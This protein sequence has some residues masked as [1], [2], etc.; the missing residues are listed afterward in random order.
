[1]VSL[2][3]VLQLLMIVQ[4]MLAFSENKTVE[5]DAAR[6]KKAL[7][8]FTVVNFPNTACDSSTSGRNGTCYTASECSSKGGSSSGSCASSFGVCCVFEMSCGG[9]SVSENSTYF[10]SSDRTLGAACSLTICKLQS[11]VCQLRLDFESF[12]LNNPVTVTTNS[13]LAAAAAGIFSNLGACAV[14]TFTV[15]SPGGKA[16]PS[17]C[18]TN[19]GEHMYV[20]ASDNCNTLSANIGSA[21]T[22]TTSAFTIKVTQIECSSKTKAPGGCLQYFT[23][24]TGTINTFNFQ[25]NAGQLLNDQDYSACIRSE[26]TMCTTCYYSTQF[27]LS[28]FNGIAAIGK[29]GF[30]T[31]CGY[32]GTAPGALN[33][34]GYDY[35]E[36][37]NGQCDSPVS[38]AITPT[39]SAD[40]YCGTE[41]NCAKDASAA[42]TPANTVCSSTRPFK[43]SV[44]SDSVEYGNPAPLGEGVLANN[45]GF[46]IGY[47]QKTT[48]LTKT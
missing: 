2:I 44:H 1:M 7:S 26:R 34:G 10:T 30:D 37:P 3:C 14:D 28:V 6:R 13:N 17:I 48:C 43:V 5:G 4:G 19:T 27:T 8:V 35:I 39:V 24:S 11:D 21:S 15:S 41:L 46:S 38:N 22:A 20:P 18:G 23:G 36:I 47:F 29:L 42:G 32:P 25:S 9:G 16:P 33:G 31:K 40:R 12:A 45:R